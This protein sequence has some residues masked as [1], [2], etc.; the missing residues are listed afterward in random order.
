MN[1][2]M[3]TLYEL[4]LFILL[5]MWIMSLMRC[6]RGF[7]IILRKNVKHII[8]PFRVY[9]IISELPEKSDFLAVPEKHFSI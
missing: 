7:L 2:M 4:P 9:I 5:M 3:R 8:K 6:Y 1:F